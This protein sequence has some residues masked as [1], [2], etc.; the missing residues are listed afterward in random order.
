MKYILIIT[1]LASLCGC[2]SVNDRRYVQAYPTSA[3]SSTDPVWLSVRCKGEYTEIFIPFVFLRD[4]EHGPY[5][6]EIS[7][8]VTNSSIKTMYVDSIIVSIN[9]MPPR[10]LLPTG[11]TCRDE[12]LGMWDKEEGTYKGLFTAEL[13]LGKKHRFH[14]DDSIRC[15]IKV[16]FEPGGIKKELKRSF[17]GEQLRFM[18]NM[19]QYIAGC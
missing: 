4:S 6:I 19:F 17:T 3:E 1:L 14:T 9:D 18:M 7:A 8:T 12:P 10:E 13:P 11:Q 15:N 2:A 16:R 5:A